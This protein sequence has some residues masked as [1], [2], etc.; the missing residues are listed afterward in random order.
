M[1]NQIIA[2]IRQEVTRERPVA[3]PSNIPEIL[4]K[5]A[6]TCCPSADFSVKIIVDWDGPVDVIFDD[7]IL[8]VTLVF[9]PELHEIFIDRL[10]VTSAFRGQGRVRAF[11]GTLSQAA[12]EQGYDKLSVTASRSDDDD[13]DIGYKVFPRLGFDGV[14]D[15]DLAARA[16]EDDVLQSGRHHLSDLLRTPE[17]ATWWAENGVSI[18]LSR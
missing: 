13:A 4:E 18:E 10:D 3:V 9:H 6:L 1:E 16:W 5:L 8:A 15:Y 14:L 12:R 11:I 17:G 2:K 7:S